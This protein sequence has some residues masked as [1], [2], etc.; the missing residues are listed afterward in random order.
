VTYAAEPIRSAVFEGQWYLEYI[1][2]TKLGGET[3]QVGNLTLSPIN[4]SFRAGRGDF[5]VADDGTF[6]WTER[7]D[8]QWHSDVVVTDSA[9]QRSFPA[10]T[11]EPLLTVEGTVVV[12]TNDSGEDEKKLT[13]TLKWTHGSGTFIRGDG[14]TGGVLIVSPDGTTVTSISSDG[15]ASWPAKYLTTEWTLTPISVERREEG[16]DVL[17]EVTTFKSRRQSTLNEWGSGPLP[18][19][20]RIEVKQIR[21]M[22]LVPRG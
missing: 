13:L 15:S 2:A 18:V 7:T 11:T 20:E 10:E 14:A 9:G 17:R 3:Q 6:N 12:T 22:K 19:I 5:R 21:H 8:G 4:L 16:P 1:V